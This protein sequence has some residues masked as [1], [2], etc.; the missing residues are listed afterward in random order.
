MARIS[1][2][3]YSD[4]YAATTGVN[5]FVEVALT[6]A[7]NLNPGNFTV[8]FYQANGDV[9]LEVSLDQVLALTNPSVPVQQD[10][11]NNEFVYVI[12]ADD[13]NFLITDPDSGNPIVY[14][15]IALTDTSTV[16]NTVIDFY[17]IGGGTTGIIAN[18]GAADGAVSTNLPVLAGPNATTTTL[19]F[20]QPDPDTLTFEDVNAGDSGAACFTAGTLVDTPTG[21]LA[22]E[23]LRPGDLVFTIDNGALPVRW[24]GERTVSG[25]GSLAPIR[26]SAGALGA[27]RDLLVSPQHRIL[28]SGWQSEL[29]FAEDEVLVP[30]KMLANGSTVKQVPCDSVTYVHILFDRHQLLRTSGLISESFFPGQEGLVGLAERT[31]EEVYALFPELRL[32]PDAY[33]AFARPVRQDKT[34]RLL[35]AA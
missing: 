17:D 5:E 28:I 4:A 27:R 35:R 19:Q 7:E 30:A 6:S 29:M 24:I 32:R 23:E 21:P 15:G 10:P 2:L 26:I 31:A 8:S 14:E 25:R 20:N 11:D 3:H 34:V 22:I 33:G 18:G 16:P 12:S 13:F 1:E 9:G